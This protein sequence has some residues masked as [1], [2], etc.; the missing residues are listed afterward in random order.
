[1]E[2]I[3]LGRE[4]GSKLKGGEVI[5]FI[6]DLGAG[7]T[8]FMRGLAEGIESEDSVSSPTF[9]ISNVYSGRDN[10]SLHHYDFYRLPE[11]GLIA[12]DLAEA[13]QNPKAII[14]VEWA[15]S[16]RGVLPEDRITIEIIPIDEEKREFKF[17]TF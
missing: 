15:E 1:E 14:C 10:L 8:S 13:I 12:E 17:T 9:T 6:G 4:F 5:E 7:K 11:P 3:D 2:T 16:V